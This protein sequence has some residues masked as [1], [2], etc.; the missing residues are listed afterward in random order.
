[1]LLL[2]IR[3][4]IKINFYEISGRNYILFKLEKFG[5]PLKKLCG[6]PVGRG[7]PVEKHWSKAYMSIQKALVILGLDICR[8]KALDN[9]GNITKSLAGF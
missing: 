9:I 5:G 3:L 2:L 4:T 6:P 8:Y 1:M 7:P